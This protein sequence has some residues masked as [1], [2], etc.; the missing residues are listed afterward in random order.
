MSKATHCYIGVWPECGCIRFVSVD[1]ETMK[2]NHKKIAELIRGGYTVNHVTI[3]DFNAGKHG[4]FGC[5]DENTCPNPH[6]NQ[7]KKQRALI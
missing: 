2:D 3:A 5:K 4:K 1:D 7:G 6:I